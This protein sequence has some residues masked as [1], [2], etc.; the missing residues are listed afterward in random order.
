MV[1]DS[2]SRGLPFPGHSSP[3]WAN[4]INRPSF[5]GQAK[6]HVVRNGAFGIDR[7]R[8]Q[9]YWRSVRKRRSPTDLNKVLGTPKWSKA[10]WCTTCPHP[11]NHTMPRPQSSLEADE[12]GH[13]NAC[14]TIQRVCGVLYPPQ[15]TSM[16]ISPTCVNGDLLLWAKRVK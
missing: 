6:P 2:F 5:T 8:I 1:L 16:K 15:P 11:S 9:V 12:V 13:T 4:F 14:L 7:I 3:I 10:S